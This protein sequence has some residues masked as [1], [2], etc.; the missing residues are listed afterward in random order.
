M[1]IL[2][3]IHQSIHPKRTSVI[4]DHPTWVPYAHDPAVFSNSSSGSNR[5]VLY[6]LTSMVDINA[7][8]HQVLLIVLGPKSCHPVVNTRSSCNHQSPGWC[9]ST[10]CPCFFRRVAPFQRDLNAPCMLSTPPRPPWFYP[11]TAFP[12]ASPKTKVGEKKFPEVSMFLRE[13]LFRIAT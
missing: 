13:N 10:K 5:L 4:G 1:I 3:C 12:P 2:Q 7:R 6:N 11:I 8:Y 9:C